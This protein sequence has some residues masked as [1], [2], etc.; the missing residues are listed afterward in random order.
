VHIHAVCVRELETQALPLRGGW[1]V[2]FEPKSRWQ[3]GTTLHGAAADVASIPFSQ[4]NADNQICLAWYAS[5]LQASTAAA[6]HLA[7]ALLR[8]CTYARFTPA[9][10][11]DGDLLVSKEHLLEAAVGS[12]LDDACHR[13]RWA[14]C[15]PQSQQNISRSSS[16]GHTAVPPPD[17]VHTC[18]LLICLVMSEYR[19]SFAF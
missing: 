10:H 8:G 5:V 11:G 1:C 14:S 15:K 3:A 17:L 7:A 18:T 19:L 16:S 2:A 9:I 4:V 12:R 13:W 6:D